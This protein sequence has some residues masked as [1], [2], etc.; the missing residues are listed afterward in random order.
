MWKV[1]LA[2]DSQA[3]DAQHTKKW[4]SAKAIFTVRLGSNSRALFQLKERTC[5]ESVQNFD[6]V[7]GVHL[8]G[9]EP[10]TSWIQS[11]GS[12]PKGGKSRR[13]WFETS[14]S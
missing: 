2:F 11:G 1:R 10:H 4:L 12:V 13:N 14:H 9:D 6:M 7:L 3:N 8:F 5:A